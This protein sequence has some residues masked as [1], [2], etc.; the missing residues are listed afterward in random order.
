MTPLA[1]IFSPLKLSNSE[2]AFAIECMFGDE[3]SAAKSARKRGR[4]FPK[5]T[6]GNRRGR[7][8]GSRNRA[9]VL[10]DAMAEGQAQAVL[11]QVLTAALAGDLRAAELILTRV[12][13]LRKGRPLR[14]DLPRIHSAADLLK[15]SEVLVAA[16]GQGTLTPDEGKDLASVLELHRAAI[17]THDLEVRLSKL[18][19][20]DAETRPA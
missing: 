11:Q 16:V 18:E 6:S 20:G 2:G 17:A 7:P 4:P 15:A 10:L 9:T 14:L 12:W 19:Q 8:L 1:C 13:A 3:N 5:G